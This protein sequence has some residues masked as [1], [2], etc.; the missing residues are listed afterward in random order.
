M[1][2]GNIVK[3]N[4]VGLLIILLCFFASCRTEEPILPEEPALPQ[5]FTLPEDITES[6]LQKSLH[7]RYPPMRRSFYS[8][9]RN[10]IKNM[11]RKDSVWVFPMESFEIFI[12]STMTMK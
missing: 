9:L 5:V 11:K 7:Q 8:Y 3:K 1:K 10:V 12:I 6:P 2:G 4:I